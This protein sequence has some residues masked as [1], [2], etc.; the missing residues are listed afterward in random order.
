MPAWILIAVG[1]LVLIVGSELVVRGGS[2]LARRLRISP[3]IIGLTVVSIGT[4][5]PELA[6]GI[7]SGL[8]G[9]GELAVGT[10]AGTNVVNLLLILG[11]STLIRPFIVR[12]QTLRV[13]LPAMGVAALSL[14]LL[15]L[16]GSLSLLDGLLLLTI[17]VAYTGLLL[18]VS[19]LQRNKPIGQATSGKP[20]DDADAGS[21]AAPTVAWRKTLLEALA[22]VGGIVII[23][24]GA[25]WLVDGSVEVAERFGVS[26]ALIG[27]TIVAIGT[28]APEIATTVVATIRNDRD[29]AIGNLIG[30]SVYNIALVVGATAVVAGP[31]GVQ[32][33]SELVTIDLPIMAG[34]V[35]LCVPVFLSG[36]R[37]GRAEGGLFVVAYLAYLSYLIL[38]RV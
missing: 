32:L 37:V 26:Q 3:M 15:S 11:L 22:L 23:V 29:I 21:P 1:I 18:Y 35:L 2:Q 27:L 36:R 14:V 38:T 8:Q 19:Y 9:V 5:A 7:Q 10:V 33:G 17:A 6:V 4:S 16:D 20:A 31:E 12:R 25:Q 30:S 24:F 28:S 13:D 34:V